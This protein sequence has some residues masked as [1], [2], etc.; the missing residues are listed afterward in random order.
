MIR[1][2]DIRNQGVGARFAF[3]NTTSDQFLAVC[4]EQA[5]NNWEEF[6]GSGPSA[7]LADRV[8]SLC[9]KWVH[10]PDARDDVE[11]WHSPIAVTLFRSS[12][13]STDVAITSEF[14]PAHLEIVKDVVGMV[15]AVSRNHEGWTVS[16]RDEQVIPTCTASARK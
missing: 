13:P 15:N 1:F 11:G 3:W 4:G 5:W 14:E 6:L 9:P 8:F 12:G 2:V 10:E 16:H 7:D